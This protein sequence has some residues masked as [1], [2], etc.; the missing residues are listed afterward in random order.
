MPRVPGMRAGVSGGPPS[1]HIAHGTPARRSVDDASDTLELVGGHHPAA[2][3]DR[4]MRRRGSLGTWARRGHHHRRLQSPADH[5][6]HPDHHQRPEHGQRRGIRQ[7]RPRRQHRRWDPD[8]EQDPHPETGC[9]AQGA[10]HPHLQRCAA[11]PVGLRQAGHAQSPGSRLLDPRVPWDV[12]GLRVH[13]LE[14]GD[15]VQGSARRHLSPGL[16]RRP[17]G[18]LRAARQPRSEPPRHGGLL[19]VGRRA[20]RRVLAARKRSLRVQGRPQMGHAG[21]PLPLERERW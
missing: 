3:C 16:Q 17:P 9:P 10:R 18:Q 12:A 21:F 2:A 11:R 14:R 20:D 5:H 7:V 15:G 8:R 1:G 13:E 19:R 6:R 4:R